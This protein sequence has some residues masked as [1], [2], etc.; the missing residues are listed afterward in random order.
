MAACCVIALCKSV[1]IAP[2][3]D[4]LRFRLPPV[5]CDK[6]GGCTC[7]AE[8][9]EPGLRQLP[10]GQDRTSQRE[11]QAAR[12]DQGAAG[13]VIAQDMGNRVGASKLCKT[14]PG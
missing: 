13:A 4:L 2:I 10:P 5:A 6:A 14:C 7:S 12:L 8:N 3:G 9:E 1:T 11:P